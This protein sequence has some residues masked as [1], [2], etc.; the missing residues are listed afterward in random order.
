METEQGAEE[1]AQSTQTQPQSGS[2]SLESEASE[3]QAEIGVATPTQQTPI[4][5][6]PEIE[7]VEADFW[8]SRQRS[9]PSGHSATAWGLAIGLCLAFPR[10]S[11]VLVFV[12]TLA[13]I[14]RI[15]SGAHYPSDVLA[16]AAIACFWATVIL[17]CTRLWRSSLY[18]ST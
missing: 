16:G 12:A 9:F 13:S 7:M 6:T 11:G 3:S 15:S 17:W 8:D 4:Q 18:E 5:P 10:A 2:S 14:Q 1:T